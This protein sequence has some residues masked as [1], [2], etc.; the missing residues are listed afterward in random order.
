VFTGISGTILLAIPVF[1]RFKFGQLNTRTP[2]PIHNRESIAALMSGMSSMAVAAAAAEELLLRGEFSLALAD[3]QA[4]LAQRTL[5]VSVGG[6]RG[7]EPSRL[8]S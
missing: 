5:E 4:R 2:T 7:L 6:K 1:R 3:S 8:G